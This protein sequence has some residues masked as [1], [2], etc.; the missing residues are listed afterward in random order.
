MRQDELFWDESG[1]SYFSSPEGDPLIAVRLKEDYD[2]AEP[3]AN[4]ISALNLS[5]L[6]RMTHDDHREQ[7][8]RR[9]LAAHRV[10]IAQ[11][12]TAVPQMLVALDLALSPPA[13]A[14]ISGRKGSASV[15]T[16]LTLLHRSFTPRRS[17][18]SASHWSVL[19]QNNPALAE[20]AA[21]ET[22]GAALYLC[23][24]FT[25]QAPITDPKDWRE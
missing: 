13:Q 15:D 18:L 8:A 20:M 25:C 2:G 10:Q 23:E 4:S 24:N 3:S 1:G 6:A 21:R 16:W 7:M 22:S 17:I 9:I 14:V 19:G 12:P 11:A 5:R